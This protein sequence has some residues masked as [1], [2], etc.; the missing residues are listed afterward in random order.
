MEEQ[1]LD[2]PESHRHDLTPEARRRDAVR[3]GKGLQARIDRHLGPRLGPGTRLVTT[4]RRVWSGAY[5]DGSIHAGNLA[6]MAILSLFPFFIT[7]AATFSALGEAGQIDA[8]LRAFLSAVPPVVAE[9]IAPVA[10]HTMSARSGWL[11]WVGGAFGLWT[12]TGLIETIRDI[13]R[14]AYGTPA[15]AAFWRYRLLSTAITVLAVVLLL[16]SLFAQVAITAAQE[17]IAAWFPGLGGWAVA[18]TTSRLIP[19]AVLY[20]AIYLLF[21]SL[22]PSAYRARR[23]PKWPGALLV[24]G[25]WVAVTVALPGVL[26][27]FFTYDLTYGSLA[28]VMIALFFFWLVGLGMVVGAELNAALAETPEERD[29]LGQADNRKRES[30]IPGARSQDSRK[31][32]REE[33][34]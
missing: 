25:W 17:V 10:R 18:L 6:Y 20:L 21:Y 5:S 30:P 34:E 8:S 4:L 22:T 2:S 9:V 33:D 19:A 15:T 16:V 28:G 7:V 1:P 3:A 14:R 26:R 12:V 32:G 27:V 13:L 24:T 31:E 11:L 23:Y 29:M